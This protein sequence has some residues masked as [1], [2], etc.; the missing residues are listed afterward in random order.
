MTETDAD[1]D[2]GA[3][4]DRASSTANRA[5]FS[6]RIVET[7][8]Y[9]AA[10]DS[11]YDQTY[12]QFRSRAALQVPV[13]RI[14]G[15]TPA[16]QKV[17]AHV[18]GHVP[19]L[20]IPCSSPIEAEPERL[21]VLAAA[22][23]VALHNSL[24]QQ[25]PT[26]N[27]QST[28]TYQ[29]KIL[30]ASIEPVFRIDYYGYHNQPQQFLKIRLLNPWLVQRAADLLQDG[31]VDGQ[32]YQPYEAH[33]PYM[34]QFMTDYNLQG[35]N[36]VYA[37]AVT[38]RPP[39]PNKK[40]ADIRPGD[41]TTITSD[42]D[43]TTA[44]ATAAAAAVTTSSR[45][46]TSP[47]HAPSL[48]SIP[49]GNRIFHEVNVPEHLKV[50]MDSRHST[51]E[52][53]VDIHVKDILNV[54]HLKDNCTEPALGT[55]AP[56]SAFA[57]ASAHASSMM[58]ANPGLEA[59]WE[60]ERIRRRTRGELSNFMPLVESER[61]A[62]PDTALTANERFWRERLAEAAAADI[63]APRDAEESSASQHTRRGLAKTATARDKVPS[64]ISSQTSQRAGEAI[65][66]LMDLFDSQWVEE[67]DCEAAEAQNTSDPNGV[68]REQWKEAEESAVMSQVKSAN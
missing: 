65:E 33:V 27:P 63:A 42:T 14:Y 13:L 64:P 24:Q 3:E 9:M 66:T 25:R 1:A 17:C 38:F 59:L 2:A 28:V 49:P 26:T 55:E 4:T 7:D 39:L 48:F 37:S 32:H 47:Q 12:F 5:A 68:E 40:R 46:M 35:M 30:V 6:I 58:P 23:D 52:L 62:V 43:S 18:H 34:L 8:H 31:A 53:E 10:A 60:D 20:Y 11:H 54:A 41:D 61:A 21:R 29:G 45:T 56:P 22:L 57:S 16:G 36:F 19:Y 50:P 51:C 67:E 44:A 15:V